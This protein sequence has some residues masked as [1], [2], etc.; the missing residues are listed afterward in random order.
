MAGYL[1]TYLAMAYSV[2][3]ISVYILLRMFYGVLQAS[4]MGGEAL[5][6]GC[7]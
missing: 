4:D 3:G 6:A 1:G 5:V 7:S 2:V